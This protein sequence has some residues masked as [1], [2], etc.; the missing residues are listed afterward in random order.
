MS[1][2][3]PKECCHNVLLAVSHEFSWI[4][5]QKHL[6]T[7]RLQRLTILDVPHKRH[8]GTKALGSVIGAYAA[9]LHQVISPSCWKR[10]NKLNIV[11]TCTYN[12]HTI[13]MQ[14]TYM[15]IYEKSNMADNQYVLIILFP[16]Q[17]R[18]FQWNFET[19]HRCQ[20][21]KSNKLLLAP[22]QSAKKCSKIH[23][24]CQQPAASTSA[25]SANGSSV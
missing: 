11:H 8:E 12:I 22:Q 21:E 9:L 15:I 6:D 17:F 13:Y 5:Y 10:A 16:W 14:C 2:W 19:V 25:S 20:W 1:N 24:S 18:T 4:L 23:A 7:I 3:E